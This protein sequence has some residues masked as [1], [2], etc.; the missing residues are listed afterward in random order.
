MSGQD[1]WT[2]V[3]AAH[4][5]ESA[6][7]GYDFWLLG[8]LRCPD[9]RRDYRHG[10]FLPVD[11]PEDERQAILARD[12][13]RISG[14]DGWRFNGLPIPDRAYRCDWCWG[15]VAFIF[16]CEAEGIVARYPYIMPM[17]DRIRTTA[18]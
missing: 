6:R 7:E 16:R 14:E 13:A 1:T 5:G 15:R 10:R 18:A 3:E 8:P 12:L 2:A 4:V 11:R 17:L 9:C